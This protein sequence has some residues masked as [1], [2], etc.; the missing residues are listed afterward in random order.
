M[1]IQQ[2]RSNTITNEGCYR[3]GMDA[4]ALTSSIAVTV[5]DP[6]K[7]EERIVNRLSAATF[8]VSGRSPP[9]HIWPSNLYYQRHFLACVSHPVHTLTSVVND[10]QF[11]AMVCH[12]TGFLTWDVFNITRANLNSIPELQ[13]AIADMI[14]PSNVRSVDCV[15]SITMLSLSS[16]RPFLSF[17]SCH[18]FLS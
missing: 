17:M 10:D 4:V 5:V 13:A 1:I 6:F 3:L 18:S 14:H 12:G 7:T 16:L 8:Q 2:A 15:S 9:P 11:I